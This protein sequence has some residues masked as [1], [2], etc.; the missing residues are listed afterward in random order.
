[1]KQQVVHTDGHMAAIVFGGYRMEDNIFQF[2]LEKMQLGVSG[3]LW[4]STN[5]GNFNFTVG[6]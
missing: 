6:V 4:S 3:L 2:D 5:C 1:M